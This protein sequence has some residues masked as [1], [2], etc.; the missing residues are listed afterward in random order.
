MKAHIILLVLSFRSSHQVFID[1]GTKLI[2]WQPPAGM[3]AW[4]AA[5]TRSSGTIANDVVGNN[6]GILWSTD[7]HRLQGRWAGGPTNFMGRVVTTFLVPDSDLWAFGGDNFSIEFVGQFRC[8]KLA[9]SLGPA[10]RPFSSAM[11]RVPVRS[12]NG[13]SLWAAE[14]LNFHI[15]S[16]TTGPEFLPLVP[17]SPRRA[18]GTTWPS[19]GMATLTRSMLMAI[20]PGQALCQFGNVNP[21]PQCS[22]DYRPG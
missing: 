17:F 16:P 11:T 8:A 10:G 3:R 18:N 14:L 20:A 13:F 22:I 2:A 4:W 15:N 12:I 19:S 5:G 6:S 21:Q 1:P 7:H 9:A